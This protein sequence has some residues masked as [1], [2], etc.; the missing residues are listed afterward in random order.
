[1]VAS[2]RRTTD[3]LRRNSHDLSD[4]KDYVTLA[5]LRSQGLAL[6]SF[7]PRTNSQPRSR[8]AARYLAP[9]SARDPVDVHRYIKTVVVHN[10]EVPT[11]PRPRSLIEAMLN[12]CTAALES[13]YYTISP[14][15]PRSIHCSLRRPTGPSSTGAGGIH[16]A[17]RGSGSGLRS[18]APRRSGRR[19]PTRS[20]TTCL[21]SRAGY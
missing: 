18:C 20:G 12:L 19:A 11:T 14:K 6:S 10:D 21:R 16:L 3:P 13:L 8:I 7:S 17:A 2:W 5:P 1:M 9:A 4:I 15:L